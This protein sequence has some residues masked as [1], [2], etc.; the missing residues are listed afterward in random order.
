MCCLVQDPVTVN[1]ALL[2]MLLNLFY[3]RSKAAFL[4]NGLLKNKQHHVTLKFLH[5]EIKAGNLRPFSFFI[6]PQKW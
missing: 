5:L 1:F 4:H 2:L 6:V 3:S